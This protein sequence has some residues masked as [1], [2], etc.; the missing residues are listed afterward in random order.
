MEK[1]RANCNSIFV[2]KRYIQ[3]L[4]CDQLIHKR[5]LDTGSTPLL[6]LIHTL[7][8]RYFFCGHRLQLQCL[9][10]AKGSKKWWVN[11]V[12]KYWWPIWQK[13]EWK[14]HRKSRPSTLCPTSSTL[15]SN[16]TANE[17]RLLPQGHSIDL[18]KKRVEAFRRAQDGEASPSKAKT[19]PWSAYASIS[20]PR[21]V[22]RKRARNMLHACT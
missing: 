3:A 15:E 20:S 19:I 10:C 14:D 5:F 8:N 2:S 9:G 1:K 13:T 17:L 11:L 22:S 4:K 21:M 7:V 6:K 12:K 16:C 18:L